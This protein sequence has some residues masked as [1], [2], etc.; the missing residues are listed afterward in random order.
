MTMSIEQKTRRWTTLYAK[1]VSLG[2]RPRLAFT[3][4]EWMGFGAHKK[5]RRAADDKGLASHDI[6]AIR[7]NIPVH[8][9]EHDIR[10]TVVHEVVHLRWPALDH[11][12]LFYA[13]VNAIRAGA[14]APAAHRRL[15]D[16]LK[17][18]S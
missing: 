8:L 14:R 16:V 4:E 15:P 13:R 12:K 5:D 2:Y 11:T 7:V 17:T 18:V 10:D 3:M 6:R 9:C 1:R